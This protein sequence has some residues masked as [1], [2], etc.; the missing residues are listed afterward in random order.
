MYAS[1]IIKFQ[2]FSIFLNYRLRHRWPKSLA[3]LMAS[4]NFKPHHK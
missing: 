3:A 2:S 4:Q 1:T